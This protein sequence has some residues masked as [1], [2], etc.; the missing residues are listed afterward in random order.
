MNEISNKKKK[1]HWKQFW[2]NYKG[3]WKGEFSLQYNS[4]KEIL[5]IEFQEE[6]V[7]NECR[8]WSKLI[9]ESKKIKEVESGLI[10][11]GF[12]IQDFSQYQIAWS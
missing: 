10:R 7:R 3:E 12:F 1:K 2:R 5:K 9:I 8:H 11:S 4:Q 6:T